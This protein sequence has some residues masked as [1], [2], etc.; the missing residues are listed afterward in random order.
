[1]SIDPNVLLSEEFL[2]FA[3]KIAELQAKKKAKE[4][5]FKKVYDAFL[6]EIKELEEEAVALQAKLGNV[7]AQ[8][9]DEEEVSE[10]ESEE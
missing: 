1:M 2:E 9:V 6:E 4:T 5:E 3:G 10:P 7:E 8:S